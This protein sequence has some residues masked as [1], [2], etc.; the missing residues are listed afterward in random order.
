MALRSGVPDLPGAFAAEQL[1]SAVSVL[2]AVALLVVLARV[3][4]HR[5]GHGGL[6]TGADN[7]YSTGRVIAIGWTL[8]VGWM[9]VTEAYIAT[10]QNGTTFTDLL[11]GASNLY[12]VLLGA[13]YAA[14]AFALLSTQSKIS[15][16]TLTKIPA[17][18]PS[19]AD[20][21]TDDNGNVDTY[22]FQYTLFN[23]LALVI[24]LVAFSAHPGHGLPDIPQFLA[25][26]TGGS[27]LTYSVNKTIAST[28][29]Q[30][31][32][33]NPPT[34]RVG[35]KIT[36]TGVQLFPNL[37]GGT[38]P[39]VTI[40]G[41]TAT[42]VDVPPGSTNT[43]IA[44]IAAPAAGTLPLAGAVDVIVTPPQAT[45]IVLRGGVTVVADQPMVKHVNIKR[46]AAQDTLAVTGSF[47]L[48]PGADPGTATPGTTDV[49]GLTAAIKTESGVE[50]GVTFTGKYENDAVTLVVGGQPAGLTGDSGTVVKASL[51]LSRGAVST[52]PYP[53]EYQIP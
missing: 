9:V 14:A 46:F 3:R 33:V 34:A 15:Q 36:I 35:D 50:F 43:L 48:P 7:R 40:G 19:A 38:H 10:K 53:L 44:S 31:T 49:D 41:I 51:T 20:V 27:A 26:L 32:S 52:D 18:T 28:G 42:G 2:G 37:A 29:P 23:A 30:I 47:L 13:P 1:W 6:I 24:V 8:V 11:S 12:F 4:K 39:T 17:T 25:I 22:D 21:I 5:P 16:G 45:P